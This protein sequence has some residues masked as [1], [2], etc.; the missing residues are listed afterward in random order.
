M[1]GEIKMVT[2]KGY[3]FIKGEKGKEYFFHRSDFDGDW[4]QLRAETEKIF[5]EFIVETSNKGPRA[6]KVQRRDI[7]L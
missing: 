3:G 7:A 4:E 1:L 6:A 2:D 5:V